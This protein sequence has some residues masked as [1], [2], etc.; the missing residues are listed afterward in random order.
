MNPFIR[1]CVSIAR[2]WSKVDILLGAA[3]AGAGLGGAGAGVVLCNT[4]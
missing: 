4:E 2:N 1:S 3:G